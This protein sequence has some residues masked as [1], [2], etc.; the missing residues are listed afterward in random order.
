M[1]KPHEIENRALWTDAAI[2][3][4]DCAP[5]SHSQQPRESYIIRHTRSKDYFSYGHWTY[6]AAEA[7]AF[8]SRDIALSVVQQC[9]LCNVELEQRPVTA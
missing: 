1:E 4:W 6:D 2:A 5:V 8:Q 7:Q 3:A 9:G